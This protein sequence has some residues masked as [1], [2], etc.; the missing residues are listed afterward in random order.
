MKGFMLF[1]FELTPEPT[2]LFKESL[3]GKL[4]KL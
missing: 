4:E 2:F 1:E 3:M